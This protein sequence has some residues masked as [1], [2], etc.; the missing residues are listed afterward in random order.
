MPMIAPPLPDYSRVI[1]HELETEVLRLT[2]ELKRKLAREQKDMEGEGLWRP[3]DSKPEP[4]VLR[5]GYAR[6]CHHGAGLLNDGD[7]FYGLKVRVD[8]TNPNVL[9]VLCE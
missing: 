4:S 6:S 2:A 5:I 1:M 7:Q 3:T 8:R 9:E